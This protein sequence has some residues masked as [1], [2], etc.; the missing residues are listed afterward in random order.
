MSSPRKVRG[1]TGRDND[2]EEGNS[3]N[4]NLRNSLPSSSQKMTPTKP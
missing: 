1:K 3:G 2:E 4:L